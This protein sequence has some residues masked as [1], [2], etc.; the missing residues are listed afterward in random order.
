[1]TSL[2]KIL[3]KRLTSKASRIIPRRWRAVDSVMPDKKSR[4][5]DI[6]NLQGEYNIEGS[7][8][9]TGSSQER[10]GRDVRDTK[11]NDEA[12]GRRCW[13]GDRGGIGCGRGG[14]LGGRAFQHEGKRAS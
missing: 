9:L 1:M 2:V 13:N 4:T 12:G 3:R 5:L 8:A 6:S 7:N 14:E 11:G 10:G